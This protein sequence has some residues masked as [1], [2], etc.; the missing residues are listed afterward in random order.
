MHLGVYRVQVTIICARAQR[1]SPGERTKALKRAPSQ[2]RRG[3]SSG[4]LDLCWTN[5]PAGL[6]AC[7]LSGD[8]VLFDSTEVVQGSLEIKVQGYFTH[9]KRSPLAPCVSRVLG[10]SYGVGVFSWAKHPCKAL[11]SHRC[12]V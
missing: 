4:P 5:L 8:G 3:G 11:E 1:E 7:P 6:R 10:E 12:A 9:K 2:E